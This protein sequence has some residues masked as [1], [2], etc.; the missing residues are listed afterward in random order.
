M[1]LMMSFIFLLSFYSS[2]AN[3]LDRST[4][5]CAENEALKINMLSISKAVLECNKFGLSE[6]ESCTQDSECSSSCCDSTQGQCKVH[7]PATKLFCSKPIGESCK[8]DSFCAKQRVTKCFIISTGQDAQGQKSCALRCFSGFVNG[9]CSNNICK[10]APSPSRPIFDINDPN[11]CD[12]AIDLDEV[13][14]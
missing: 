6:G 2:H 13:E 11:R 3:G 4:F 10:P 5:E 1:K 8:D 14:F 7:N 12:S 9:E